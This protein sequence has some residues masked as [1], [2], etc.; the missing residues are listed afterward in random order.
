MKKS[1]IYACLCITPAMA[2]S[3]NDQCYSDKYHQYVEASMAW[4]HNLVDLSVRQNPN[5]QEV[6]DWFIQSRQHHFDLNQSA[7]NWYLAH[8]K[9]KLN[10][11]LPTES[12][13]TLTQQDIKL[14]SQQ[15]NELGKVA[16]LSFADRQAPPHAQNYQLRSQ[17]AEL[18]THPEKIAPSLNAYNETI[19]VIEETKCL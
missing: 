18:L 4:Y 2:Y 11:N 13:L 1:F 10:L 15:E 6:G 8:D 12:W 5:L 9:Q 16:Q 19:R 3:Q 7:F 14:L 17:F